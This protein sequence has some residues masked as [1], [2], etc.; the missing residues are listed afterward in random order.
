MTFNADFLNELCHPRPAMIEAIR[1]SGFPRPV[2]YFEAHNEVSP[3][4]LYCYLHA[5]FGPPNGFQSFLRQPG[6]DNL[7]HWHWTLEH[8]GGLFD[9]Q[10]TSFRTIFLL[11]G[12]TQ[13]ECYRVEDLIGSLKADFPGHG[14]RMS[15][16]RKSLEH[17][18]EFVS[19]FQRL[20]RSIR[21]L[22][23]ELAELKI[24]EIAEPTA[25]LS[26][27]DATTQK[28]L[29]EEWREA[30]SRLSKAFGIC[31]GIRSMLP[32]MAEAFVNLL[33][34]SLMQEDLRSDQRM[35]ERMF[36]E[37]ID[38]RIRRLHRDCR[39]FSRQVDY[40]HPA[41]AAL[42]SLMNERNDLLHGN[43]ALRKLRFNDLFF[44]GDVPVFKKYRSMWERGFEVQRRAVGLDRVKD[45]LEVV[46]TFV[47]YVL[48]C[49]TTPVRQSF[50]HV[51]SRH[52]LGYNSREDR[53]GV[54][55]PEH[56]V[57]FR[58]GPE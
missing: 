3:A 9:V 48:S 13:A 4:D 29:A 25:L 38:I 32:T 56:L 53:V 1:A 17:W 24:D 40:S 22:M 6:S 49:L 30:G 20:Y 11:S 43:V 41:C 46:E 5:R 52:E 51:L 23:K 15:E 34:F 18:I 39:G 19:P 37:N 27:G 54:L 2:R 21:V 44:A 36:R 12:E 47:D 16:C 58:S 45:E 28:E 42:H 55:F 50:E 33:L 31:F 14:P 26:T 10:G 8:A 7:I 35:R 57:D